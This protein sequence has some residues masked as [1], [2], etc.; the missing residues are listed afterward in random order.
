[1]A[2]EEQEPCEPTESVQS[3]DLTNAKGV[4]IGPG[5]NIQFNDFRSDPAAAHPSSPAGPEEVVVYLR[6]L[7]DWLST[8]PWPRDQRFGS[9]A[10]NVTSLERKLRVSAPIGE[11]R[12]G[13][14]F[15][16]VDDVAGTD[17]DDLAGT[18]SRLVL[19][20]EPGSG[21][22]WFARRTARRCAQ[23]AVE[24]LSAGSSLDEVELPLYTTCSLLSGAGGDIRQAAVS[25]ALDQLPDMGDS[26][27]NLSIYELFVKRNARVI[28][29]IDSLDEARGPD[30][31][32]RQA[33]TL[34]WRILLTSRPSSWNQQL[35]IGEN[36]QAHKVA[37]LLPLRY[38]SD[39]ESVIRCWFADDPALG[40]DL[41]AQIEQRPAF[42]QAAT[43]PLILALYCIIGGG[44][45]L[46]H[47]RRELYAKVIRRMLTGRWR[48]SQ[49]DQIDLDA[50]L[51]VL[52]KW[53]WSGAWNDPVS[54]VGAWPDDVPVDYLE[55]SPAEQE[56]VDHIAV[57][58]SLPDL[59]TGT[60][61]RRFIHRSIRD[62][63]VAEL[64]ASL[65]AE[66]AARELLPHLWHDPDWEQAAPAAIAGHSERDLLLT[67]LMRHAARSQRLPG[68][69]SVID[70]GWQIRELL[71]Q[72]AA[73]SHEN[74][75]SPDI[76]RLIGDARV[77]LARAGRTANLSATADWAL[78][79]GQAC[80]ALLERH[81]AAGAS[82]RSAPMLAAAISCL[83]PGASHRQHA[84]STLMPLLSASPDPDQNSRLP[85]QLSRS[86]N[87]DD[88]QE[89]ADSPAAVMR[90]VLQLSQSAQLKRY[91]RA[92]ILRALTSPLDAKALATGLM[93]LEPVPEDIQDAANAL[94]KLV[95]AETELGNS[96]KW[97]AEWLF[98][99]KANTQEMH[100]KMISLLHSPI[101]WPGA[102]HLAK[103]L[104]RVNLSQEDK[105]NVRGVLLA[106]LTRDDAAAG[107][108]LLA[109]VLAALD[110]TPDDKT[111][112]RSVLLG[113]LAREA[114]PVDEPGLAGLLVELGLTGADV[115]LARG[116][117]V[118]RLS[119][120]TSPWDARGLIDAL[121]R[122]DPTPEG[123]RQARSALL[124]L[125]DLEAMK[126][127]AEYIAMQLAEMDP[128]LDDQ[129]RVCLAVTRELVDRAASVSGAPADYMGDIDFV[130]G[131]AR[132]PA[133]RHEALRVLLTDLA[134]HRYGHF[135][136]V[137]LMDLIVEFAQTAD[138][139]AHARNV[140]LGFLQDRA[141][142]TEFGYDYSEPL[143][144]GI[145]RLSSD[146]QEK[147]ET[148][149]V[150]LRR[151][152][153]KPNARGTL[154][155]GRRLA[156]LDISP[157]DKRR[158]RHALIA[159]MTA[160]APAGLIAA[161][162]DALAALEPTQE[163]KHQGR[164][165][166][167]A[168]MMAETARESAL[169][170]ARTLV[171][172]APTSDELH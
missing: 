171:Q 76:A 95:A 52:R 101:G 96:W 42:Q 33:D 132:T 141:N 92:A 114:I 119:R 13:D 138:D 35:S 4:Q 161:L 63:F 154:S 112:A 148:S 153:G 69:L 113:L 21:K 37:E 166:L 30:D 145:V 86:W 99:A 165:A 62:H 160:E 60:T 163:E 127:G 108:Y 123:L 168:Q 66:Q 131:L 88:E 97:V 49:A 1:M 94:L 54:G 39:V 8:D 137:D 59:D 129:H 111:L 72:V 151:L 2:G 89:E 61:L 157:E 84:I 6:T 90:R 53:A 85:L 80:D 170:L 125:L 7:I 65:P 93:S 68:D 130:S 150:L 10:L 45:P 83:H 26:R 82:P 110:A 121:V 22:T 143:V 44:Q 55:L 40:D 31:R 50:C 78:S 64:V 146:M 147:R 136:A 28:L 19:L 91:A 140:L 11:R 70:A 12:S 118:S 107:P 104:A 172:L 73:E 9:P 36:N 14:L 81:H 117:L 58:V 124:D 122:L 41:A 79:N 75:W 32:V 164:R 109:S 133:S 34:P 29:V 142:L 98:A 27:L 87:D 126:R 162:T 134:R 3:A 47:F 152:S 135:A 144:H 120:K 51:R 169:Y 46:P 24:A 43:V 18:C 74:D 48:A 56:A 100:G 67:T 159:E 106:M 158:V 155:L 71:A 5:L 77:D 116:A 128:T 156:Q 16:D 105:H 15:G 25:S 167:I 102:Y 149:T 57:P 38:P 20:G 103:V 17:A 115:D 23:A 139:R